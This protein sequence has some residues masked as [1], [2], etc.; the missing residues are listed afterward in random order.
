MLLTP[1]VGSGC[2]YSGTT[3]RAG[4]L[5]ATTRPLIPEEGSREAPTA[6]SVV[7]CHPPLCSCLTLY[8]GHRHLITSVPSAQHS[9]K[10]D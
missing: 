7:P 9:P 2:G 6:V 3:T 5:R 10:N 1:G 4:V 8:R